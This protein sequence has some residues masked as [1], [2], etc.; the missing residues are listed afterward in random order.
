MEKKTKHLQKKFKNTEIIIENIALG[1]VEK[2]VTLKQMNDS[3]SSTIREINNR[4]KYYAKKKKFLFNSD[5][6]INTNLIVNQRTLDEYFLEKNLNKI[7]YLKIDTEGY[8]FEVLLGA[9]N[10][11]NKI[12]LMI[13]EH[14]YDDMIKKTYKFSDINAFLIQNNFEQ[15][16]KIKMPF[17]K[18]FE[19]IYEQKK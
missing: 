4:S 1:S 6:D 10:I 17:R 16:F 18:T 7:D 11:L 5:A 19:Y 2:K 14:H 3:S 9:K 13:I 12:D 8:E 15:V